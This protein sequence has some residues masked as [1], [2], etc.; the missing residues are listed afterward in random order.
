MALLVFDQ[1]VQAGVVGNAGN[2]SFSITTT[3]P[4]ELIMIAYNGWNG[5]AQDPVTVDGFNAT[6]IK[7]CF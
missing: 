1:A 5:P 2:T 4:N 7:Y 3:N 6:H